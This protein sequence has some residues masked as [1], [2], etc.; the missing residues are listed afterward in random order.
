MGSEPWNPTRR[1]QK[2]RFGE[3]GGAQRKQGPGSQGGAPLRG[4]QS[5]AAVQE[6]RARLSTKPGNLTVSDLYLYSS[7]LE[8]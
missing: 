7:F 2:K 6:H 8:T 1:R 4:V 3:A 5:A